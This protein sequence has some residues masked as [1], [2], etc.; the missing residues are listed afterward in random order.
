MSPGPLVGHRIELEIDLVEPTSEVR[1]TRTATAVTRSP[2]VTTDEVAAGAPA[3]VAARSWAGWI[4][5][6]TS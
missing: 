2:V 6:L 1:A 5:L 4:S 3:E